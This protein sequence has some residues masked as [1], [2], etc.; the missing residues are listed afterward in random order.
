MLNACLSYLF[1]TDKSA[2][3]LYGPHTSLKL[4]HYIKEHKSTSRFVHWHLNASIRLETE[5]V[6]ERVMHRL[7][8]Y[9]HNT[10]K[11][12]HIHFQIYLHKSQMWKARNQQIL[13]RSPMCRALFMVFGDTPVDRFKIPYFMDI[14]SEQNLSC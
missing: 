8:R 6:N 13:G 12:F 4:E 2:S 5:S 14:P 10:F 11:I 9:L 1:P 7:R 3:I